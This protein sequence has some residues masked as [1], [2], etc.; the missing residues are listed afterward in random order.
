MP[1]NRIDI[2]LLALAIQPLRLKPIDQRDSPLRHEQVHEMAKTIVFVGK[3]GNGLDRPDNVGKI[4]G[5]AVDDSDF[6]RAYGFHEDFFI[7]A[8]TSGL[9][10][11]ANTRVWVDNY[12]TYSGLAGVGDLAHGT[13][14]TAVFNRELR[15]P[16]DVDTYVLSSSE[17]VV[18]NDH[19]GV[20]QWYRW[21][22]LPDNGD[23]FRHYGF[24]YCP[25]GGPFRPFV[26]D[27][28]DRE[29]HLDQSLDPCGKGWGNSILMGSHPPEVGA[30]VDTSYGARVRVPL[31]LDL[32]QFQSPHGCALSGDPL[33]MSGSILG[34]RT[35]SSRGSEFPPVLG[36]SVPVPK[37]G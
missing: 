37:Y 20:N 7:A 8:L 23:A 6:S 25:S 32:L 13:T 22:M 9:A 35:G 34:L 15:N 2:A 19:S 11:N 1:D 5:D 31:T 36:D 24:Y 10:A 17:G 14:S 27:L 4:P 28:L 29:Q 21:S 3:M 33:H 18:N 26:R 12:Y 16:S 30:G